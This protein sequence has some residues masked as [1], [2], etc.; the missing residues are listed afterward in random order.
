MMTNKTEYIPMLTERQRASNVTT[1]LGT[2]ENEWNHL[3]RR[4]LVIQEPD[5]SH[6]DHY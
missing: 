3:S 5:I 1:T 6:V 2:N 4:Q